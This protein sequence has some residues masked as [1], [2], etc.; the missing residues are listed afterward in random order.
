MGKKLRIAFSGKIQQKSFHESHADILLLSHVYFSGKPLLYSV[1]VG[2]PPTVGDP[3]VKKRDCRGPDN[4][5]FSPNFYYWVSAIT[6]EG[7]FRVL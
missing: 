3:T 7:P 5:F 4:T 2:D 6:R 1:T